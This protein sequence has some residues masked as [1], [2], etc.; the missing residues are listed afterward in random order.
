VFKQW[1]EL[2]NGRT[3]LVEQLPFANVRE[4]LERLPARGGGAGLIPIRRGTG[5]SLIAAL[6]AV[7]PEP[8]PT[9][10]APPVRMARLDS[11]T[12]RGFVLDYS[13]VS[14]TNDF[15]FKGG[16]YYVV[17]AVNL[18]GTTVIEGT[19]VKFTN[20]ATAKLNISGPISCQTGPFRP[21]VFTSRDDN[22]IGESIAGSTGTPT[23]YSG[24][25]I[26]ITSSGNSLANLR[27]SYPGGAAL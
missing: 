12:P 23:N 17:N 10:E 11:W 1:V 21:A 14:S 2:A 19:T 26:E 9:A 18:T 24:F 15:T 3:I 13:I 16:T 8:L 7:V 20:S 6:E 27:F 4:S 5:P 25:G 22:S